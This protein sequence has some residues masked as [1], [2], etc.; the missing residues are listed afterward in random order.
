MFGGMNPQQMQG[1]MRKM[2]ISQEDISANRVIIEKKDGNSIIIES[3]VVSKIKMQG[4]ESFQITGNISEK[5]GKIEISDEDIKMITEKTGCSEK[6][7]KDS[8]ERTGDLAQSIM[9]LSL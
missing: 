8:L 2:G 7:A 6:E 9:E 4:Q 3:P 1:M 5:S